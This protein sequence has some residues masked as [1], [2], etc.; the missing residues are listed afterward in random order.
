[1]IVSLQTGQSFLPAMGTVEESEQE[2]ALLL[3]RVTRKTMHLLLI[4]AT[5][6]IKALVVLRLPYDKQA[7]F[8]IGTESRPILTVMLYIVGGTTTTKQRTP[9]L[10]IKR[11]II[12]KW[13]ERSKDN[14]GSWCFC[15]MVYR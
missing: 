14:K 10:C 3:V 4:V 15:S 12:V 8:V 2:N 9:A 6:L 11:L 5:V 13:L 7:T 1:M